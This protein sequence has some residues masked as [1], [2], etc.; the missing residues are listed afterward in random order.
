MSRFL[1]R[2]DIR[3]IAAYQSKAGNL[4]TV[5]NI[6]SLP[7]RRKTDRPSCTFA[8]VVHCMHPAPKHFAFAFL[9]DC[10]DYELTSGIQYFQQQ[11][12]SRVVEIVEWPAHGNQPCVLYFHASRCLK[13]ERTMRF[14]VVLL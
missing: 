1:S 4:Y 11:E 9:P 10:L 3:Q 8:L 7:K 2:G 14:N 12:Q 6:V 13:F 5:D